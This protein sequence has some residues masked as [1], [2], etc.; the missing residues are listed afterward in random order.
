[1]VE[2]GKIKRGFSSDLRNLGNR[3]ELEVKVIKI[4]CAN[5]YKKPNQ[6]RGNVCQIEASMSVLR[7]VMAVLLPQLILV[8]N[9]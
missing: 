5:V 3:I 2:L 4:Y 9:K 8:V 6:F 7:I 1:M